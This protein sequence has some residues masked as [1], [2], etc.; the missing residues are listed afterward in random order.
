MSLCEEDCT[1]EDYNSTNKR[2]KCSC[3]VKINF[4]LFE[5]I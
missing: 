1:L 5:E 2:V 3:L 4:P